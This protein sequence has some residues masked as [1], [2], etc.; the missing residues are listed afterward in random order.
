MLH[1]TFYYEPTEQ[2]P[3]TSNDDWERQY[4]NAKFGCTP[5]HLRRAMAATGASPEE[6]CDYLKS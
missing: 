5:E 1:D 6:V 3:I 2:L 4:W